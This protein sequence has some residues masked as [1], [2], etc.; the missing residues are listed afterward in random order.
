MKTTTVIRAALGV[1]LTLAGAPPAFGDGSGG[2]QAPGP[3]KVR[4]VSCLPTPELP[5]QPR[6]TLLRGR[7]LVARGNDLD[8]VTKVVFKG[9]RGRTDDTEVRVSRATTRVLVARVPKRARTGPLELRTRFGSRFTTRKVRVRASGAPTAP[10]IAPGSR[11]FY[12]SKRKPSYSFDVARPVEAQVELIEV[13][14]GS[15]VRTWTISATPGTPTRVT[16]NGQDSRGAPSDPGRYQFR[17]APQAR[18]AAAG[19]PPAGSFAFADHLFPIRG[20]HNLGYSATNNFGGPR[21]HKGQD[22][23]ARCG[24]RL[25]AARGGRVQYAGYHSA[26][27]NY[28]VIDGAGT[29]TDYVYMH[30]RETPLVRT[31]ERVST[32][33][34]L[35]EVGDSGRATGCHLHFEL[36][37][38]P[39]WYE[40]GRAFDPL[41]ALRAWDAYS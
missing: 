36:W 37:S 6:T 29:G 28:A 23:F 41:P 21:N 4:T 1:S 10:D 25:A 39:G 31:G 24:T 12:G 15:L 35:G 19:E 11:F 32:G 30:M 22:M 3:P 2:A 18:E 26:A 33:Q 5:C 14:T 8:A 16:W 40:G 9:R 27:G 38:G 7:D 17:L 34:A 13:T 20:R